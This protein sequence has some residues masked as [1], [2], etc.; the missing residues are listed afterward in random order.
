MAP[1]TT[2]LLVPTPGHGF[3]KSYQ[4]EEVDNEAMRPSTFRHEREDAHFH[5]LGNEIGSPA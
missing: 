3:D 1:H 2:F 4:L 5:H